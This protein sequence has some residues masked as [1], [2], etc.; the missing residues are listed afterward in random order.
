MGKLRAIIRAMLCGARRWRLP[1]QTQGVVKQKTKHEVVSAIE[2]IGMEAVKLRMVTEWRTHQSE[3]IAIMGG[4]D[5]M[6]VSTPDT[7][8]LPVTENINI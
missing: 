8:T 6:V 3:E 1:Y 4:P 2:L 5:H 7:L